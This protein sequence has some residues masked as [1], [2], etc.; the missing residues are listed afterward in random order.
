MSGKKIGYIRI[1][2]DD[3]NLNANYRKYLWTGGLLIN[4]H[5]KDTIRQTLIALTD[6]A[7]EDI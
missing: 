5:D 6:Y 3:Q 4:Y 7:S 1:S 2:S